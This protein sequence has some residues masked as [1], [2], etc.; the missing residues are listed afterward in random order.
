VL[1][2]V[3]Q[4]RPDPIER[5]VLPTP[6][7]QSVLL[8]ALATLIQGLHAESDNTERVQHRDRVGQFVA[9]RV[10]VAAER[11]Q[12]CMRDPRHEPLRGTP[13]P[14]GADGAG[15]VRHHIQQPCPHPPMLVA[16]QPSH[17]G[18]RPVGASM[19]GL[20]AVF[21][22]AQRDHAAKLSEIIDRSRGVLLDRTP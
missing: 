4:Q 2:T 20:P 17:R 1:D 13:Q 19:G 8:D 9:D 18:H 11:V 7:A 15:S 22:N 16:D 5:V 12:S 3:P 10:H 21:I 6:V 14:G